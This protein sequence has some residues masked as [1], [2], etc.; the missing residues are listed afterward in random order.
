LLV[1]EP[2]S[3]TGA[4]YMARLGLAISNQA[5][6]TCEYQHAR[7]ARHCQGRYLRHSGSPQIFG[8]AEPVRRR[9][10]G[11]VAPDAGGHRFAARGRFCSDGARRFGQRR[12]RWYCRRSASS[13]ANGRGHDDRQRDRRERKLGGCEAQ[14]GRG[15]DDGRSGR[16]RADMRR[17]LHLRRLERT[18]R[19]LKSAPSSATTAGCRQSGRSG[20]GCRLR[21]CRLGGSCL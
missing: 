20:R 18:G 19:R 15:A 16:F 1:D 5:T 17:D 6:G 21:G 11:G 2:S 7:N 12:T 9:R 10:N 13:D 4:H 3:P 8:V 14:T